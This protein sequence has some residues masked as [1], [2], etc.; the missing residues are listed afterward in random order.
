MMRPTFERWLGALCMFYTRPNWPTEENVQAAFSDVKHMD[1]QALEFM[2]RFIRSEYE[3][4]PRSISAAMRKAYAAWER[5]QAEQDRAKKRGVDGALWRPLTDEE[6]REQARRCRD[7]IR[8]AG[9]G[10]RPPW[11]GQP[12]SEAGYPGHEPY[13]RGQ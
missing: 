13:G 5:D 2:G 12:R 1:G 8:L 6:A 11:A 10:C 9:T 7:I 3:E 4:W